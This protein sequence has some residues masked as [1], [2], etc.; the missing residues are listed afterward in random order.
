MG[1]EG[2][3]ALLWLDPGHLA[4]RKS[5]PR[6][7]LAAATKA[8]YGP[9]MGEGGETWVKSHVR[10]LAN[11]RLVAVRAHSRRVPVKT[12]A[13]LSGFGGFGG[14]ALALIAVIAVALMY[15]TSPTGNPAAPPE[16]AVPARVKK[17]PPPNPTAE[18]PPP[19]PT[20]A[21]P[22]PEPT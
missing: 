12:V 20:T 19:E 4:D 1:A 15:V 8:L 13:D 2:R 16:P 7:R 14:L 6:C 5:Y 21:P 9:G 11:G 22:P 10:R 3:I 18:P 17:V